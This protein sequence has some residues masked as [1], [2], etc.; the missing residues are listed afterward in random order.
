MAVHHHDK[1]RE[2]AQGSAPAAAA[3]A[4]ADFIAKHGLDRSQLPKEV[5]R[6]IE[7][8]EAAGRAG[9]PLERGEIETLQVLLA[10]QGEAMEHFGN[11]SAG[12]VRQFRERQQTET[13]E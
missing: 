9:R 1:P 2:D 7:L 11:A 13:K 4:D 5:V 3:E 12:L 6:Q 8:L 10:T